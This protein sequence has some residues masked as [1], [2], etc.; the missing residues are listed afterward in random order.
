MRIVAGKLRGRTIAAPPGALVRPTS[1]RVREAVFNVL[2]HGDAPLEGARVLDAFAGSGALG[3]EALSRGAAFAT[4]IDAAPDAIAAIKQNADAL[5]VARACRV[6]RGDAI[7]PPR[8]DAP[9]DLVFLDP[10]YRSGLAANALKQLADAGW[11]A[12]GA[13]VVVELGGP[14]VAP[15]G[16][17]PTDERRYGRTRIAFLKREAAYSKSPPPPG[18]SH[19]GRG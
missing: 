16:F 5:D 6:I 12:E 4:F 17:T 2:M 7:R 3:L 8:A 10:P 1:D 18:P 19:E 11:I 9:C 14:F 13:T 15:D